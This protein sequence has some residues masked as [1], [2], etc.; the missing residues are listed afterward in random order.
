MT[1]S[2]RGTITTDGLN[3][4]GRLSSPAWNEA[5]WSP[6]F[7]DMETGANTLYKTHAAVAAHPS[8]L[9]IGFRVEEPYPSATVFDRDGIVFQDNDVEF[10]IDF[11]WGYYEFEINAAGTVYEVMH[12]WRDSFLQSPFADDPSWSLLNENVFTF[13]GDFDRRPESFW[14]GT[15]PRGV[16]IAHR[17]YDFPGLQCGVHVDGSLNDANIGGNGW[18]AEVLLP[19]DELCRLS[20]GRLVFPPVGQ[21][22]NMFLG[23]FQQIRIGTVRH[24][25]A[26]C[27][28]RHGVMDTHQPERFT[29]VQFEQS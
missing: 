21:T 1:H 26:W 16:R 20:G 9:L 29:S 22:V 6:A 25:A 7:V 8:G 4:D 5:E 13:A 15:H 18:T 19:W 17:A 28:T 10:F 27:V 12:V 24:T 14:I 2:L 23:R 3:V 11:G